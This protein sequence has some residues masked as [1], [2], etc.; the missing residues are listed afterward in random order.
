[1]KKKLFKITYIVLGIPLVAFVFLLFFLTVTEYRPDEVETLE[2]DGEASFDL[3]L[4][5]TLNLMTFN[6]GYASLG[7]DE[8]FVMDGGK[9]G[10]PESKDVVLEYL[11]GI[12]NLLDTHES[13]VYFLQEV[14]EPSRRSYDINQVESMHETVGKTTYQSTFA[15]N[16]KASLVPFPVSFSDYIGQV[17]SGMQTLS[18]YEMDTS[19][20][21]QFPG[22]FSWPLRTANLK[23]AM[24]VTRLPIVDSDKTLVLINL[25]MSAYDDGSMR[26]QEMA[27]FK[28]VLHEERE[29]GNYVIA[30]GDFNQTFPEAQGVYPVIDD[31]YFTAPQMESG[32]LGEGF[33]FAVD[34]THPT[35]RLLNTPYDIDSDL[36][37]YYI[38]DGFVVS[39]NVK[40]LHV[41][42]IDQAFKYSDHNPV[43]LEAELIND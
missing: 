39:D 26:E 9:R 10:R 32:V 6:I 35:S 31:E 42:T 16:F 37:Q 40:V 25:H 1:M 2:I 3:A 34:T 43:I 11:Q 28:D 8:D 12:E 22:E 23:R 29:K 41:E 27:L 5:D 33:E 36:T 24:V 7:E 30:G 18:R 15:Y 21:M 14:D 4:D 13:D 19:K 20:R 38:I 17:A